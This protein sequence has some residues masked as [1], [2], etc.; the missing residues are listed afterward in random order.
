MEQQQFR[1]FNGVDFRE[2]IEPMKALVADQQ[3]FH[4]QQKN[5]LKKK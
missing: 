2:A 1:R 5:D 4:R 3:T